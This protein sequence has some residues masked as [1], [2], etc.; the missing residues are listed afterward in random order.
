MLFQLSFQVGGSSFRRAPPAPSVE[1]NASRNGLPGSTYSQFDSF[2]AG[3]SPPNW[4]SRLPQRAPSRPA[5]LGGRPL[6]HVPVRLPEAAQRD[7]RLRHLY[8]L[9]FLSI[10][11]R[12]IEY[13]A[14]TSNPN[15][16]W[17]LQQARNLLMELDDCQ[18]QTRFLVHDRDA[19]F[20]ASRFTCVNR[21][22]VLGG[23]IHE[24]EIAPRHDDR[25]SAPTGFSAKWKRGSGR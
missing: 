13:L 5:R 11:S 1:R 9:V 12:R 8:V 14:C 15:T 24:Y 19:K 16:A 17:M 25:V 3:G 2:A 4:T 22:D 10:G 23:L 18:R 21:R 20:R 7:V 6:E